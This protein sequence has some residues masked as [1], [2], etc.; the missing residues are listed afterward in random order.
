[1]NDATLNRFFSL[2]FFLPFLLFAL[3]IIHIILLHEFGS[4]NPTGITF[5]LDSTAMS[6]S[7]IIKDFLGMNILFIFFSYLVFSIPNALGHPDNYIMSNP[8]VT[9]THIVPE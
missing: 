3:S 8:V 2:H 7:Y 1:M 6:P 5:R 9:P 4:S